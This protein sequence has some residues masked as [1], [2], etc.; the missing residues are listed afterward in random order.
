MPRLQA[1]LLGYNRRARDFLIRGFKYGFRIGYAGAADTVISENHKSTVRFSNACKDLLNVELSANRLYGPF[2]VSPYNYYHIS[3]I[4]VV[5]KKEAGKFR[6]IHDLSFPKGCSV[7]DGI[8]NDIKSVSYE[9]LDLAIAYIMSQGPGVTVSKVDIK[10]AF[11]ICPVHPD[12]WHLL[13]LQ[14]EGKMYFDKNLAMGLATSCNIFESFSTALKW[15]ALKFLNN[16]YIAKILDDFLLIT[17]VNHPRPDLAYLVLKAIFSYLNVPLA[18]DKCVAPCKELVYLGLVIDVTNMCIKLPDDKVKRCEKAILAL[19]PKKKVRLREIQEICGLLQFACRAIVPG[20]AFLR[21]LYDAIKGVSN[22]VYFIRLSPEI[23]AD[24]LVW[25]NFLSSYNGRTMF[26]AKLENS[27]EFF[28]TTDAA[29]SV[30]FGA[31]C[32]DLWLHGVWP[33]EWREQCIAV[34]ELYPII[35][36]VAT[37]AHLFANKSVHV[38]TDNIAL[39]P[40]INKQ[41][42]P[43]PALMYLIRKL[44]LL[45]LKYNILLR[46]S[47][48]EGRLNVAADALSRG[49]IGLFQANLPSAA[50]LPSTIPPEWDCSSWA[51]PLPT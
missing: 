17:A 21:R 20:R 28:I 23:K 22:P 35:V 12:D 42:A 36:S 19:L 26:L 24:L 30:G 10:S 6:L 3:P 1:L 25:L 39:V 4:G 37:W 9:P 32:G 43:D 50:S 11:R 40:V 16:V 41:T 38:Y 7:N 8:P 14:W 46:A 2:S 5:P 48:I 29:K 15:I 18:P 34:L 51:P 45:L 44:V 27:P 47:H 13:G 49:H 31:I 33:P